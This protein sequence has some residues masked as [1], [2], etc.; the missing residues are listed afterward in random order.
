MF[1]SGPYWGNNGK[2]PDCIILT[3]NKPIGYTELNILVLMEAN[4]QLRQTFLN[5]WT[6][7][8]SSVE[9]EIIL[10]KK[11]IPTLSIPR[12]SFEKKFVREL[13]SLTS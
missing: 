1:F 2:D 4:T 5:P 13:V 9:R 12:M 11:A 3:V 6:T 10:Q 7:L 8:R